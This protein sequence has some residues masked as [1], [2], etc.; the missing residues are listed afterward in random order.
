MTTITEGPTLHLLVEA[1]RIDRFYTRLTEHTAASVESFHADL[2]SFLGRAVSDAYREGLRDGFAQGCIAESKVAI[3]DKA[4]SLRDRI[5]AW[6]RE[7][8]EAAVNKD[9]AAAFHNA[10]DGIEQ[11]WGVA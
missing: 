3:E 2:D 7:C 6:L 10:A 5:V 1:Q 11:R 9:T 4:A 8:E